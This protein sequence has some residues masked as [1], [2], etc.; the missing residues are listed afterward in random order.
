[1]QKL[2]DM[3]CISTRIVAE[4]LNKSEQYVRV[5]LQQGRL[6]FGV[7]VKTSSQWSY[8]ISYNLLKDYIGED[9]IKKY[10]ESHT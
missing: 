10:E 7:A 4:L 1:M 9:I 6:P 2:K 3:P 8:H 5:G